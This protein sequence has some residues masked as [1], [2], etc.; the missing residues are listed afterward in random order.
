MSKNIELIKN[1][2]PKEVFRYFAEISDIPRGSGNTDNISNYLVNFAIK[3]NLKYRKDKNQNVIIIKETTNKKK[4]TIALQAHIDMVCVKAEDS[5]KDM[6][7]EGIDFVVD[8]DWLKADK[9]TLGADDGIGMAIILAMLSDKTDYERE[10]VGIFTNDEEIGL[11]GAHKIDLSN[12]DIKYL[13]NIDHEDFDIIDVGC[14]GGT[15]LGFERKCKLVNI[16]SGILLNLSVDGLIGGHSGMEI[17]KNHANANKILAKVLYNA[18]NKIQFNL[19]NINGGSFNNAIPNVGYAQ[20]IITS[21]IADRDIIRIFNTLIAEELISYEDD[22]PDLNIVFDFGYNDNPINSLS[23]EDTKE[24]LGALCDLPDG[25]I[26]T[27]E[28]K[29]EV[30]ETSLNLGVLRTKGKNV[31]I[32]FLV[33]SNVNEKRENLNNEVK[34][35]A[36]KYQ[37]AKVI[38]D[39]Y[40]AWEYKDTK[41]EKIVSELYEKLFSKKPIVEIT[42]AG[43]ECGILLEKM[44]DTE[45]IAIG[46]TIVGAHTTE[47]RL[48]ID[49][50]GE[51]HKLVVELI[52][53]LA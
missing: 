19:V 25:L 22:E 20:I 39:S 13:I 18:L 50:V 37:F 14:A 10:I 5:T 36:A 4:S 8:G 16:P 29:P 31:Y 43:L 40:P 49:K 9:T 33:R 15:Q 42:H 3:N 34:D 52:K 21:D 38:D 11:I 27:F 35:I 7:K 48:K 47:E 2:E 17:T 51:C 6:A 32:E 41:L 53:E 12:I 24:I 28:D 23:K 30:A 26:A 45:A 1:L 46:P 44:K